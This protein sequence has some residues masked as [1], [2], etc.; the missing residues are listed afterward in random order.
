MTAIARKKNSGMQQESFHFFQ[1]L[2]EREIGKLSSILDR[3]MN[4]QM[5]CFPYSVEGKSSGSHRKYCRAVLPG[6]LA[7]GL[8]FFLSSL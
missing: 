3:L 2:L 1:P 4:T 5:I 6:A 8:R 7:D